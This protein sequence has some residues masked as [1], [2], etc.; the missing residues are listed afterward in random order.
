MLE[1]FVTFVSKLNGYA[2]EVADD[3]LFTTPFISITVSLVPT[4]VSSL[5]SREGNV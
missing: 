5:F 3:A 1:T 4:T 2:V